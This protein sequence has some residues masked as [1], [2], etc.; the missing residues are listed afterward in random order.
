MRHRIVS[1]ICALFLLLTVAS[2]S[3]GVA[4]AADAGQYADDTATGNETAPAIQSAGPTQAVAHGPNGTAFVWERIDGARP[5]GYQIAVT[6]SSPQ[7]N[8]SICARAN[9]SLN[10][11]SVGPNGTTTLTTPGTTGIDDLSVSL[12]NTR[13][14]TMID[15]QPVSLQPIQR[16]GDIDDDGLNNSHEVVQGTNL[17]DADTDGDGLLD[18]TEVHQHGT[19]P[20]AVDTDEDGVADRTEIQQGTDPRRADTDG[21]GLADERELTLG[22]N[23]TVADTDGD[24]LSDQREASGKT[25]PT[26]A[27]TDNDG[28]VDG[29][30]LA[31]GTNPAQAD[32]DADGVADG[33]ELALGTDPT[34][35]DTDG[36]GVADGTELESGTEPT[37]SDTDSDGLDDG[38]ELAA[39]T[40]PTTVDTDGDGLSDGREVSALGTDPLASDSDGD[41]LTDPQEVTWGTNPNSV[42]TPAWVTSSLLGFLIGIGLTVAA[43]RR[44]WVIRLSTAARLFIYR[45][46]ELDR[47]ILE[48]NREVDATDRVVEAD[49]ADID[50]DTAAGAFEQADRELTPDAHLVKLMLQAENGR[51][52]QTDIV[53]ATDWSKAKVSRLLSRMVDE[54][55]VVKIRLGRE[56]LICLERAKP[57]AAN[58]PHAGD[59]KPPTPG[60]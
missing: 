32:T 1:G 17:T 40:S 15:R 55:E 26:D 44:G 52:H 24:G 58:S 18:G 25:D 20:T 22:T 39:G 29:R 34:V 59:I 47:E 5:G 10:C 41:F 38:R 49:S 12:Y 16:T 28:V 9:G 45:Y 2:V 31:V 43:I 53:E 33:R 48:I 37:E 35:A 36:D 30:E 8:R 27:D 4:A 21:D 42:L 50:V 46:L 13:T 56:N 19:A 60:G 11:T 7:E 51:L 6:V 23:P 54:D 3:V 57:P 14:D